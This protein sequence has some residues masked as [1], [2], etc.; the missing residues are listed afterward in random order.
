MPNLTNRFG[1][2]ALSVKRYAEAINEEIMIDKRTGQISIKSNQG[3]IGSFDKDLRNKLI[4]E[5][6]VKRNKDY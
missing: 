2:S 1:I 3:I 4:K 6:L 5:K